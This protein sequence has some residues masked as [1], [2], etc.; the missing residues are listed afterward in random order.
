MEEKDRNQEF[1]DRLEAKGVSR[2]DFLKYCTALTASMGLTL[3][4]TGQV[5][6]AVEKAAA[7]PRPPVIWLH[8]GECTGCSEAFLRT[9]DVG[10]I[11]LETISVEYHETIMAASGHQAEKSLHDAVE[12]YKGKFVCVVEG[13]IATK[14][15]G[16]YGKVADRSFLEIAKSIIPNAAA[17]IA[18]GTCA[19][20]GGLPAAAPNP[21][22]YKGVKDAIGVATINLPGCPPNPLNLLATIV[23]YLN[24]EKI[25]LDELGRPLF[26]YAETVHDRCPR[27]KH[28]ENDEYVEEF[29][30]KEAELGYCL[31]KMGCRGPETYNNCPTA[32]FND[33]TSFPIQAGHPCIGCSE[34]GF[35]DTMTPFYEEA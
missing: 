27:L 30:S 15:N 22:G 19:A 28:F 32:K 18:L 6:K 10:A 3:S 5:V 34:P 21:G 31:Y 4:C 9:P 24:K 25:E 13:S 20:Y 12:K 26:A 33:G 35:W 23:K 11:I 16:G 1:Y 8:F 17:T 2:R 14:Y 29:G 7:S